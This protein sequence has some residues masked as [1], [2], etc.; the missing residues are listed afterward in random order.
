MTEYRFGTPYPVTWKTSRPESGSP[1]SIPSP[2]RTI[3]RLSSDLP[4]L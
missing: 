2:T 4:D 3:A 1:R